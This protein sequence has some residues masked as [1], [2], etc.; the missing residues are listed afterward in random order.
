MLKFSFYYDWYIALA[1]F[2]QNKQ[3]QSNFLYAV[4]SSVPFSHS[5]LSLLGLPEVKIY[6]TEWD[7]HV[8]TESD[9]HLITNLKDEELV[10]FFI[11][12]IELF[13]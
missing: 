10:D 8:D 1:H 11:L 6:E 3:Y 2:S 13:E 4:F 12:F 9:I 5:P 7:G